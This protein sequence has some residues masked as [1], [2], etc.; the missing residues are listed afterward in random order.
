MT[1]LIHSITIAIKYYF[2]EPKIVLFI[3]CTVIQ[4]VEPLR[5]LGYL[6]TDFK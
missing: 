6:H 4:W 1:S 3:W 5:S 2:S